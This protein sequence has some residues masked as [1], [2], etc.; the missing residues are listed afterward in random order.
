MN[1]AQA[2]TF[3]YR[4][5]G[6]PAVASAAQFTDVAAGEYYTDAVAWAVANDITN[7]VSDNSFAPSDNCV[8]GQT[9][10]FLYRAYK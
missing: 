1:R 10:T 7:G 2:V 5:K 3:L 9:V 4:A 6:A 8:R